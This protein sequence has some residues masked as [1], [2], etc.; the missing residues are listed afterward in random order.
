[1]KPGQRVLLVGANGAGKTTLLRVV[2]GKH[3]APFDTL[4]VLGTHAPQDQCNG[5]SYLGERWCYTAAFASSGVA[6]SSD[7]KVRDMSQRVQEKF[8]ERRDRLVDLL[9][10]DMDWRMHMVSDGQRRRVQIMLG[11]L[12]PFQL[13]LMD[14]VTVDLDVVARS[15]L[16]AFLKQECDERQATVIFATHIY[17][18]LD[19]WPTHLMR[20]SD[21]YTTRVMDYKEIP[22]LN[23]N[24]EAGK[25]APLHSTVLDWLRE[26]RRLGKNRIDWT[27]EEKAVAEKLKGSQGGWGA[28]RALPT[29]SE[30]RRLANIEKQCQEAEARD[31]AAAAEGKGEAKA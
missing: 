28:G 22:E 16:L 12:R 5:V 23:A 27:D 11:L 24:I 15:D 30:S 25:R 19:E 14:E 6:Y 21:G 17:D 3:F 18:G 26:E 13:L 10:I 29:P 20:C 31:I 7:I 9:D 1:M 8:S 2:S 4:D